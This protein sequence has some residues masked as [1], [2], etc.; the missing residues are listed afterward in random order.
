M[1]YW[2]IGL[3][4]CL[5][6]V[7]HDLLAQTSLN[8]DLSVIGDIRVFS[9]DNGSLPAEAEKLIVAD[10]QMEIVISGYLNPY[11]RAEAVIG[12]HGEDQAEIEEIYGTI[13]RG[14]PLGMNLRAGKYLLEYGRL[15]PVH[16]H[17]WSFIKRPLPHEHFFGEHGL[18][19]MA[20]RASFLLPTGNAYTELMGGLLKGDALIGHSHDHDDTDHDHEEETPERID[21]GGFSRLTTSLAVSE[22]SELAMGISMINSV[23]SLEG[24]EDHDD[25]AEPEQLRAGIYGVDLKFKNKPSRYTSLQVEGEALMRIAERH[26]GDDLKSY[27]GYLYADYRFR[28]K[29]NLGGIFEFTSLEE[30]HDHDGELEIHDSDIWRAGLFVGLA[31]VEETSLVRLT[32]HWTESDEDDGFWELALQFVFSL[33]PHQPH[34]F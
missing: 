21:L 25:H 23:Y 13:L 26:E 3:I 15:N 24:H 27:G 1:R 29:Y 5:L 32:G 20:I 10:P 16:E 18:A 22:N 8:P 33:G 4:V 28:Q 2:I 31:P 9:H 14:L 17:A 7:G 11:A 19:D 6:P 30:E 12:W 34:N